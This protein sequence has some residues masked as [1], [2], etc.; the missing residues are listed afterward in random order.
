[1]QVEAG[2]H[3]A[4]PA[5]LPQTHAEREKEEVCSESQVTTDVALWKKT[6]KVKECRKHAKEQIGELFKKVGCEGTDC[7]AGRV[8]RGEGCHNITTAPSLFCTSNICYML[9]LPCCSSH[10]SIG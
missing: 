10:I 7:G 5:L 2:G 1:M 8:R 4:V 6:N 3:A 9:P